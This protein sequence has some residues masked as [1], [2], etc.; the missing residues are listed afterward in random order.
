MITCPNYDHSFLTV[1]P[2]S[3]TSVS[4]NSSSMQKHILKRPSNNVRSCHQSYYFK[5]PTNSAFQWFLTALPYHS[6]LGICD[7]TCQYHFSDSR[8][9]TPTIWPSLYF[10]TSLL[11]FF[12]AQII[13]S[14]PFSHGLFLWLISSSPS[15]LILLYN[16]IPLSLSIT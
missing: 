5:A 6:K 15:Y 14:P 10:T 2:V 16:Y 13:S 1:P 11:L 12:Y 8:L 9:S 3:T 7:L 4:H